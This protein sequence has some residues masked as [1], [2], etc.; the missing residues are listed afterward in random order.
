MIIQVYGHI[1]AKSRSL[2]LISDILGTLERYKSDGLSLTAEVIGSALTTEEIRKSGLLAVYLAE[3][4][5]LEDSA[6]KRAELSD[7]RRIDSIL[8][9]TE[10]KP[11]GVLMRQYAEVL[12][13]EDRGL[14]VRTQGIY[15][16]AA[17]ELMNTSSLDSLRGRYLNT[18]GHCTL[19]ASLARSCVTKLS[20]K[21]VGKYA[22][23]YK[24]PIIVAGK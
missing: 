8:K 16:R 20:Y 15:L 10:A 13:S 17:T 2:A 6:S 14:R 7:L 22:E 4:G 9:E 21:I 19:R 11:W 5:L 18:L 1:F 23:K 3:K 12:A 24:H